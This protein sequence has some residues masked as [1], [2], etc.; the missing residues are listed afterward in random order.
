MT[1]VTCRLTAKNQDQLQNP[2]LC[3]RVWAT[4][5]FTHAVSIAC[6]AAT[7]GC[8]LWLQGYERGLIVGMLQE[9]SYEPVLQPLPDD[10]SSQTE[11]ILLTVNLAS[12]GR[13]SGHNAVA[14]NHK[15]IDPGTFVD[16]FIYHYCYT[17]NG[18]TVSFLPGH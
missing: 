18:L 8:V 1:H 17:L 5:T 3:N 14:Q 9:V 4:F 10:W 11:S 7:A 15:S 16:V 13:I 12:C 6:Q 2:G